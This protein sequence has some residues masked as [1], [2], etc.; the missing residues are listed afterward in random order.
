MSKDS[1]K[2]I[3]FTIAFTI[4]MA[5]L[6]SGAFAPANVISTDEFETVTGQDN[7]G[8]TGQPDYG[9]ITEEEKPIV[10]KAIAALLN[11]ATLNITPS[12]ISVVSFSKEDFPNAALGCEEKGK[13]YAQ[14]ITPGYKVVLQANGVTY[15]YRLNETSKN[16][17]LCSSK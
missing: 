7:S 1:L 4:F 11:N 17:K 16:I 12:Q 6:F 10:D 9:D 13:V 14:V 3:L 15:D 5:L 2:L 8:S